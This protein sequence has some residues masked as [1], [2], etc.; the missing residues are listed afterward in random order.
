MSLMTRMQGKPPRMKNPQPVYVGLPYENIPVFVHPVDAIPESIYLVYDKFDRAQYCIDPGYVERDNLFAKNI[1]FLTSNALYRA[2]D[3]NGKEF[4]IPVANYDADY[5]ESLL[6][7]IEDSGAGNGNWIV[8]TQSVAN[9]RFDYYVSHSPI[10]LPKWSDSTF[11]ELFEKAFSK[12]LIEDDNHIAV[13]S[14]EF[15]KDK[16]TS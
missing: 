10:A 4:I 8:R 11:D 12:H 1:K 3:V 6:Q 9:K 13:K 16:K 14:F 5:K 7:M 2:I 15:M